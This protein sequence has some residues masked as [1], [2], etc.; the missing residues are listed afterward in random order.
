MGA[1]SSVEYGIVVK[2]I[3]LLECIILSVSYIYVLTGVF[4]GWELVSWV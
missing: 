3:P 4:L 1:H 2:S